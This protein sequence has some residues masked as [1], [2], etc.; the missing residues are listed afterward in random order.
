MAGSCSS[1]WVPSQGKRDALSFCDREFGHCGR[2]LVAHCDQYSTKRIGT[3]N[4]A[5]SMTRM[6]YPRRDMPIIEAKSGP[7]I[8][9]GTEPLKPPDNSHD[10]NLLM[11]FCD[12]HE[13]DYQHRSAVG[14]EF[15]FE[16]QRRGP[17]S[18]MD[19]PDRV[20]RGDQ[21]ASV[22]RSSKSA[23]KQTPESNR[24]MGRQSIEPGFP[25]SAAV[26]VFPIRA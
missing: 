21:P 26:C 25:T 1:G 19:G 14:D 11:S 23:A 4:G 12:R 20:A 3:G 17:I 22:R 24:G 2:A 9:I 13:I 16:D 5:A 10:I 18:A 7:S 6:R 15:V 8:R